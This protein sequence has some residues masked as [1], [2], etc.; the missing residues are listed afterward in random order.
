[1]HQ[2]HRATFLGLM[3]L[4]SMTA[5]VTGQTPEALKSR[6]L[7]VW[8]QMKPGS[9]MILRSRG[10]FGTFH[11]EAQDGNFFY[12]TGIDEPKAFLVLK[13]MPSQGVVPPPT[14]SSDSENGKTVLFISPR[15]ESRAD[16]D[17][18]SLGLEGAKGR[19][20]PDVR[21]SAEFEDYFDGLLMS[22]IKLL[23]L[24]IERSRKVTE[25]F[26]ADE[27]ILRRARE[28]G[29]AFDLVSPGEILTAM[30]R[31][32]DASEIGSL[33][34][35]IDI[36]AEA[37]V[38]AI[39]A[40][41]PGLFE[42]QLQAVVEYVFTLN[43]SPRVAFPCII[44]SG[45]NSCILHWMLN[46]KSMMAGEVVVVDIG[47]QADFYS[48][49]ITRTLPVSGKF[50]PR[51][52]RVYEIVLAANQ[53]AIAMVAPGADFAEISRRAAEMIGEGLVQLGLIKD[54]SEF[55][56]YYFHGLGHPIGLRVGGGGA[57]GILEP[58]M[59]LTIE[60]GVYIRE[61]GLGVRI[62]DDVLVTATGHE[63][64]SRRAPK[65]VD[66]IESLMRGKGLDT[67]AHVLK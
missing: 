47:A 45:I 63:V 49:D 29:A 10:S 37:Q 12:L 20:F 3:A 61:E 39:Q 21:P 28:K 32:R 17:A 62:E 15:E 60:P 31:N 52:R 38:A 11:A 56:K 57:L 58:G 7:K 51:Q 8:E 6:R 59:V 48:A 65:T 35:A 30:G 2:S 34:K 4:L 22:D 46:S 36:T 43:G 14:K 24:D 16:W 27:Q 33:R 25:P 67:A 50:S 41:R 5:S 53:A 54:K 1:M 44:G 9:V 40:L 18:L 26:T 66:E 64:L 19:S 55:R 42:Y 13:K 23:Y